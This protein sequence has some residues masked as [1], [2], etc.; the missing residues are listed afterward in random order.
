[1]RITTSQLLLPVLL[2]SAHA[3]LCSVVSTSATVRISNLGGGACLDSDSDTSSSVSSSN[4]QVGDDPNCSG[5]RYGSDT[6]TATASFGSLALSIFSRDIADNYRFD[7]TAAFDDAITF[8]GSGTGFLRLHF[9]GSYDFAFGTFPPSRHTVQMGAVTDA[10][11]VKV[12]NTYR[13]Q[14]NVDY[15]T[16]SMQFTFGSPAQIEESIT[17]A[18]T[19]IQQGIDGSAQLSLV[20]IDVRD[21]NGNFL[22]SVSYTTDSGQVYTLEAAPVPEPWTGAM[23]PL[24]G[25][26]LWGLG[27]RR[28]RPSNS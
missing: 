19:A 23:L 2:C 17:A 20:G 12:G 10:V 6:A 1:M 7:G 14:G 27:R 15:W 24:A 16:G 9:T 18:L 21:I 8:A 3:G 25:V 4:A 13:L 5:S 28:K 22:G 11:A 26:A